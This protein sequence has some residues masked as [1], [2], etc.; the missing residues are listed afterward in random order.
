MQ[1]MDSIICSLNEQVSQHR[2]ENYGCNCRKKGSCPLDNKY[3]TPNIIYEA[4]ITRNTN[5]V[6]KKYLGAA[7]ISFKER[8]S[9]HTRNFKHKRY[10][11]CT[12]LSEYIWNLKNQGI[13]PIVKWKI[14]KKVNSII[15]PKYSK[16]CLTEKLF[17]TKTLEGSN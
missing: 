6:Y 3:L 12:E 17:I 8:Y 5:A 13:T 15:S 14:V 7:K 16:L 4:Q 9:N 10:M 1:N 2:N 11:T